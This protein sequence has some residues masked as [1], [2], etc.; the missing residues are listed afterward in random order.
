MDADQ[1]QHAMNELHHEWIHGKTPTD[2]AE[3]V[4][5]CRAL[6]LQVPWLTVPMRSPIRNR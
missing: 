6:I 2:G 4:D 3:A 5:V 1:L